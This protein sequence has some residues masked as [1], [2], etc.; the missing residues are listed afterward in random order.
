MNKALI[1]NTLPLITK[2][3]WIRF[4][5]RDRLVRLLDNPNSQPECSFVVPFFGREYSGQ[6]NCFID[7]SVYY[8]GAYALGELMMMRD[9][10]KDCPKPVVFDI[11]ANI[12]HHSLYYSTIADVVHSFEPYG[13]VADRLQEKIDR[14]KLNNV[15]LHRFGLGSE[16][17]KLSYFPPET[18]NTGTGSFALQSKSSTANELTL[19]VRC[20]DGVA[21]DLSLDRLDFVK[22]DVEGFEKEVLKGL[23]QTLNQYRPKVFVEWNEAGSQ[24][25][26]FAR[27]FP[28]GYSFWSFHSYPDFLKAFGQG[29]YRLRPVLPNSKLSEGNYFAAPQP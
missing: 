12:G 16:N 4:G 7:W 17:A 1:R 14:N 27:Y 28:E 22:I 21:K 3:N 15:K 25:S 26:D 19:E 20:G 9:Q 10:L 24:I 6:F 23:K 18:C 29:T 2:R 11:G 8:Y 13:E 5:I